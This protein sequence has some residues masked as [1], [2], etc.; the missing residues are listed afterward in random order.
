MF[1]FDLFCGSGLFAFSTVGFLSLQTKKSVVVVPEKKGLSEKDL[2][3]KLFDNE[4]HANKNINISLF[5][6]EKY[7]DLIRHDK[8]EEE[9]KWKSRVLFENTQRGNVIMFYNIYKHGFSYFSDFQIP[10]DMLNLC[11]M[12]YVRIFQCRDFFCDTFIL[13]STFVSPII[14]MRQKEEEKEKKEKE[15]K[16]KK[17]NIQ[18]DDSV[19]VKKKTLPEKKDEPKNENEKQTKQEKKYE[20]RNTFCYG[21]K[22]YNFSFLQNIPFPVAEKEISADYEYVKFKQL[23]PNKSSFKANFHKLFI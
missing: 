6:T 2:F 18:F 3:L 1:L 12:K 17:L 14:T 15:E 9:N 10:Y 20:Q 23:T 13:P 5:D 4:E 7:N 21:G 8:N 16:K 19:F 22:I 11:A